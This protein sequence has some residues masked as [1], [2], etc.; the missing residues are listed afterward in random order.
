MGPLRAPGASAP[1]TETWG[2]RGQMRTGAHSRSH[3]VTSDKQ[4]WH[5][6]G[7]HHV[8]VSDR[9]SNPCRLHRKH[10]LNRW[11]AKAVWEPQFNKL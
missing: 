7:N 4:H 6:C 11:T 1:S 9:G 3:P 10:S 8:N 2:P 5:F